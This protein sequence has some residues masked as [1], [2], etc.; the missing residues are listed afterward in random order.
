MLAIFAVVLAVALVA[1]LAVAATK[2]D[3]FVYQR[4]AVIAAPATA[5]LPL[6]ADFRAW[7]QWSPWEQLDAAM[8][9]TYGGAERGAGSTYAWQGNAQV[10]QGSMEILSVAPDRVVI[11]LQF[12]RPMRA[13]NETVFRL[14]S[15]PDGTTVVH[16]SMTG[17]QN[18]VAKLMGLCMNMDRLIGDDFERGLQ[19][20]RRLAETPAPSETAP[21]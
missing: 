16:W 10:G 1:V 12:E 2:P 14:E 5:L 21:Q 7:G 4:R 9:K 19:S 17:Q 11:R 6:I 15:Q 18:I 3:T 20:L 8:Q 13:T